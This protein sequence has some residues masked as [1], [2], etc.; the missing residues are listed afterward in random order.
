[1][2]RHFVHDVFV[3][4]A[5]EECTY[6]SADGIWSLPLEMK[7][8]LKFMEYLEDHETLMMVSLCFQFHM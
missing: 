6:K 4:H 7:Y 8:Q 1:M 5:E 3:E 2:H